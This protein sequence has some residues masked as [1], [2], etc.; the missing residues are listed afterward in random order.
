MNGRI[1]LPFIKIENFMKFIKITFF[2]LLLVFTGCSKHRK[3]SNNSL[4]QIEENNVE[5]KFGKVIITG[6]TDDL[7]AFK[8]FNINNYSS[9][10]IN[11]KNYHKN[12]KIIGDSL[13]LVL[14]SIISPQLI[15]VHYSSPTA[16]Y[17]GQLII[18]PNDTVVF[19]IKNKK[20]KFIGKNANQNNFY[21][22]L[23]DTIPKYVKQSYQGNIHEYKQNVDS[24]YAKKMKFLNKYIK[25]NELIS[26]SFISMV[27]LD[28][29]YQRLAELT[30]PGKN[31]LIPIIQ[32][33]YNNKEDLFD[34]E[35]YL[36]N[37]SVDEFKNESHL[38]LISFRFA[39]LS[40]VK[41]Y[42]EISE[43]TNYSIEKLFEN[44]KFVENN[45]EGKIKEFL[46]ATL[47][48]NYNIKGFG[49]SIKSVSFFKE[50]IHDFEEKYPESSYKEGIQ[51]IKEDLASFNFELTEFALDTKFVN[52]TGDML[53]LRKIFARSNKRIKVVD[54]W[55]SWCLPCVTEIKDGKPSKDRLS[56]ENNVEW[57]YL[58]ID[59]NH[60][61][62][63]EK[64]KELEH[65][66]NFN[67]SF[68]LLKGK[69]SS[70]AK[71]LNVSWIPRYVIFNQKNKIVLNNAPR[72]SDSLIFEK[73]IDDLK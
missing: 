42:F 62:W 8:Y 26:E 21:S 47:I 4:A 71:F 55:A 66:L 67:N 38:N 53:T 29:K 68:F 3:I 44:K 5:Q 14:D 19:E 48:F 20:L 1:I 59:E 27:K 22:S 12:I 63:L 32:K 13:F 58:S 23:Y 70:L 46:I 61:Q 9:L 34:F 49:H 25:N 56:V 54:F 57:I 45:F 16:S 7:E 15:N 2:I 30:K 18:N 52:H 69:N 31:G 28:F 60:Q 33:E 72:P 35:N 17:D 24:A 11:M 65:V 6:K 40:L 41:D 73:I 51:E 10:S 37:I 36:G 50:F 64:N 39:L 43:N